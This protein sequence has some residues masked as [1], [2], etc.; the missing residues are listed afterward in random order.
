MGPRFINGAR[1]SRGLSASGGRGRGR[2][3]AARRRAAPRRAGRG[4]RGDP[5]K[6]PRKG[7]GSR[8]AGRRGAG[9]SAVRLVL[10]PPAGGTP[11]PTHPA[12]RRRR[13]LPP[14]APSATP[15]FSTSFPPPPPLG[16]RG[17]SPPPGRARCLGSCRAVW[18]RG[19]V[20]LWRR[21]GPCA[22][23]EVSRELLPEDRGMRRDSLPWVSISVILSLA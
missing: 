8:A 22:G 20:S 7:R 19:H 17:A 5:G 12:S 3:S 9:G 2:E 4:A 15:S 23:R 10:R 18:S 14:A 6:S 16:S 13:C 11:H 1:G 21:S